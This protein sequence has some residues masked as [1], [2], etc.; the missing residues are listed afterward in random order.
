MK[1]QAYLTN[2]Y[3]LSERTFGTFDVVMYFGVSYHLRH[4]L[5]AL[6]KIFEV[7]SG[8]LHMQTS[9]FAND[10]LG[11][12]PAFA[13]RF[14]LRFEGSSRRSSRPSPTPTGRG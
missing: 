13:R 6:E 7:C 10:A 12:A 4:P 14:G 1:S 3:D 8:T 11:D 9:S 2:V 5:L